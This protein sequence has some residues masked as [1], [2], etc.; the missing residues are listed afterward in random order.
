MRPL[1]KGGLLLMG[2]LTAA[3]V[4][5]L[6]LMILASGGSPVLVTPMLAILQLVLA[7]LLLWAGLHV[8]R[9]IA[10][11]RTWVTPLSA[12]RIALSARAS[13]IVASLLV[14]ALLGIL[15]AS[16]SRI[17]APEMTRNILASGFGAA[18]GL[19]WGAVAVIVERWCLIDEDDREDGAEPGRPTASPA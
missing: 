11:K 9:F 15:L 6:S 12:M 13:A 7:A 4:A 8:K 1:S 3:L 14:G 19:A 18:A 17:G 10:R 5:G 16:L 2:A